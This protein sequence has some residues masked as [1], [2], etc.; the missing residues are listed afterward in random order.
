M[1]PNACSQ[2]AFIQWCNNWTQLDN[3]FKMFSRF[4]SIHWTKDIQCGTERRISF[5]GKLLGFTWIAEAQSQPDCMISGI[6]KA[7]RTASKRIKLWRLFESYLCAPM[8]PQYKQR[9][10]CFRRKSRIISYTFNSKRKYTLCYLTSSQ[11]KWSLTIIS[12]R[13]AGASFW[14]S[15]NWLLRSATFWVLDKSKSV[16]FLLELSVCQN[17]WFLIF[18]VSSPVKSLMT[19]L[20]NY[21]NMHKM[22][23]YA[24]V[25]KTLLFHSTYY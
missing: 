3:S 12:S 14:G 23:P 17:E 16:Y 19:A 11:K 22:K 21:Y 18:E 1:S 8:H 20:L 5:C 15:A 6:E 10:D 4:P 9:A 2:G 24:T 7:Y 25:H 13:L